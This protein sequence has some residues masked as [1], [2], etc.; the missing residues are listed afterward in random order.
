MN[1]LSSLLLALALT[2]LSACATSSA[3]TPILTEDD[4]ARIL[5][6]ELA[7]VACGL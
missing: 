2:A 5:S 1:L 4:R 3:R 6:E 7:H